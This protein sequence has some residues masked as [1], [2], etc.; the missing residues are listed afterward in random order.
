MPVEFIGANPVA[1]LFRA[2]TRAGFVSLWEAEWSTYGPGTAVLAW[3]EG[4]DSVRLL[5]PDADLGRWLTG[6]FS[7][8]FPELDGLPEIAEPVDCDIA[9][10]HVGPE[11]ARARVFGADGSSVIAA[12][13][14]P[15][16]SRPGQAT[17]WRLGD[18]TWT[19]TNLLT[20]C[21]DATLEVDGARVLARPVVE[22]GAD[23]PTSSAFIAVHETW[24]RHPSSTPE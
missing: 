3:V 10:W 13:S 4:D 24:T 8:H 15:M 17:E 1:T 6:T 12:I 16:R 5:T 20:F 23:D 9:E 19:L 22:G 11:S 2:D 18:A 21:T 14:K 7:R